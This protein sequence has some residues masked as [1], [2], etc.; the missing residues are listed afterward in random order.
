MNSVRYGKGEPKPGIL[1]ESQVTTNED[2]EAAPDAVP[3]AV[4]KSRRCS[5]TWEDLLVS[6]SFDRVGVSAGVA[7]IKS[8]NRAEEANR[9][10]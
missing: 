1:V 4:R 6:S 2:V 7:L 9:R 3:A 8:N 10:F 5:R